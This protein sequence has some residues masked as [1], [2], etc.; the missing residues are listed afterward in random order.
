MNNNNY[1]YNKD[2]NSIKQSACLESYGKPPEGGRKVEGQENAVPAVK[3]AKL[4][5]TFRS[6][7]KIKK[8]KFSK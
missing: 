5:F 1:Y 4:M 2:N 3:I 7:L 8:K 6:F